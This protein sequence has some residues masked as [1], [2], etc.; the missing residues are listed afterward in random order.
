MR[1]KTDV[2]IYINNS[3]IEQ[4]KS[5]KYLGVI[6]DSKLNFRE[7]LISTSNKCTT[8]IYTLA[9]S[10]KLYWG[11]QQGALN[12]IY[13]GAILPLIYAAP[14]WIRAMEKNYNR[15]LYTRVRLI[16]IKIAKSF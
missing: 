8:L 9:K 10:A 3:P 7:R 5:I 12:T 6:L 16:N 11:L 13:K 1:L 4:V 14:V 2:S 15:T